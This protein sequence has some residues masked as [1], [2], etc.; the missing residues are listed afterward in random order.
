MLVL[1]PVMCVL[2]GITVSNTLSSFVRNVDI[3]NSSGEAAAKSLSSTPGH[4]K[5]KAMDAAVA[6]AKSAKKHKED[7]YPYKSE[8]CFFKK[9][10]FKC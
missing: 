3:T 2:G 9:L 8:V 1:A 7:N 10:F 5:S 6:S 4:Q